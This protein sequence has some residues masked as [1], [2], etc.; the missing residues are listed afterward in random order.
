LSSAR[1]RR[2]KLDHFSRSR[3]MVVADDRI[4]HTGANAA[5][6]DGARRLGVSGSDASAEF[7]NGGVFG[8][9]DLERSADGVGEA[10]MHQDRRANERSHYVLH[11]CRS[12]FH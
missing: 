4:T 6:Q 12:E 8:R 3:A 5:V 2:K 7:A 9:A 10:T 11:L 1:Y